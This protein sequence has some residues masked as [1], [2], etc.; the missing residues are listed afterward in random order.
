MHSTISAFQEDIGMAHLANC[1]IIDAQGSSAHSTMDVI[2]HLRKNHCIERIFALVDGDLA[3]E[4]R[5]SF[6]DKRIHAQALLEAGADCVVQMPLPTQ[7]L[8]D[9]LYAFSIEAMLRKLGAIT[10]LAL[11]VCGDSGLFYR[12]SDHLFDEPA[13]YRATMHALRAQGRDLDEALP[14]A[15]GQQI[16]GADAFLALPQNRLAVECR[17]ALRRAYSTVG[18]HLIE[19]AS[20]SPSVPVPA[21][22]SDRFLLERLAEAFLA[23]P[24]K[25]TVAWAAEI[26]SGSARMALRLRQL[27]AEHADTGLI[28]FSE[29]AACADMSAISVR[30]YALSCLCGYRKVDGFVCNTYNFIP[31][32]RVLAATDEAL[33]GL[34]TTAGTT[35]IVDTADPRE[36][37]RISDVYKRLLL[38]TENRARSLFLAS[39]I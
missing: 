27:L 8:P 12:V 28:S 15:V 29:R 19:G 16:P 24:E 6:I 25:E 9:N 4:G 35:V 14:I 31:Y 13:P 22:R 10:D 11:P 2:S 17:N 18:V 39:D 36:D 38:E 23:R 26:Y 34:K 30:R 1:A 33:R 3:R 37:L 5:L 20:P 32:I 21:P 7:M